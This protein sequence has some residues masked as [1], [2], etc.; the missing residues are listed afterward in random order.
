MFSAAL[1]YFVLYCVFVKL[2]IANL[3]PVHVALGYKRSSSHERPGGAVS[4]PEEMF[5]KWLGLVHGTEKC[6]AGR[7]AKERVQLG[8]DLILYLVGSQ[9]HLGCLCRYYHSNLSRVS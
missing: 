9:K 6:S 8:M 3:F 7:L 2:V 1:G 4:K 5:R